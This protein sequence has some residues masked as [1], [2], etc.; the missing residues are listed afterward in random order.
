MTPSPSASPVRE[1]RWA[2][3]TAVAAI[4][5]DIDL[6]RSVEFQHQILLLLDQHP[7]RLVVNLTD[8]PYMDSSGVASLV[9]VLSRARKAGTTL[10]LVGMSPRVKSLFQITRLD[11]VFQ[12]MATEEEAV[13]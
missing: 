3:R 6:S 10:T 11:N 13:S 1:V 7:Q 12:I 8:V 9:K 5:G 4:Q 2:G